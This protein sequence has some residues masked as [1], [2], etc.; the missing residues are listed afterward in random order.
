[1]NESGKDGIGFI[2][3]R[4]NPTKPFQAPERPPNLIALFV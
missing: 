4:E 1:V 3:A 2:V